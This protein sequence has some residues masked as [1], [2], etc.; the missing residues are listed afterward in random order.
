MSSQCAQH[1]LIAVLVIL[2]RVSDRRSRFEALPWSHGR[3]SRHLY[4]RGRRGKAQV[5]GRRSHNIHKE[6]RKY[7]V[8]LLSYG[9]VC[10]CLLHSATGWLTMKAVLCAVRLDPCGGWSLS[11]SGECPLKEFT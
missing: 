6:D 1:T 10:V 11:E 5:E 9:P 4:T 2:R 8:G 3:V 7:Q